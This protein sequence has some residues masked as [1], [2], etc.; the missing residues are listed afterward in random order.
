MISLALTATIHNPTNPTRIYQLRLAEC[1]LRIG[2]PDAFFFVAHGGAKV[3]TFSDPT[4]PFYIVEQR[5]VT[6]SG[7]HVSRR[8]VSRGLDSPVMTNDGYERPVPE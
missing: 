3:P 8:A 4:S 7:R 5:G 2:V 1:C 6:W